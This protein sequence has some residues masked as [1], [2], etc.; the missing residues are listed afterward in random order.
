[1]TSQV[2]ERL[3]G[4]SILTLQQRLGIP[5]SATHGV[6]R[7]A[8]WAI[9][10]GWLPLAVIT[11]VQS[12]IQP[13][14][15]LEAFFADRGLQC[16]ALIAAPVLIVGRAS[17]Y[18]RLSRI[19]N[20]FLDAD[21]ISPQDRPAFE[22]AIASTR[23]LEASRWAMVA[24]IAMAYSLVL[25]LVASDPALPAWHMGPRTWL[26]PYSAAGWWHVVVSLPMLIVLLLGWFW[27]LVLWARL[28]WVASCARLDLVPPH[29]DRSAGL[30]F[31]GY[32]VR[33][34][35]PV[36]FALGVIVAGA[37]ANTVARHELPLTTYRNVCVGL[38]AFVI[39]VFSAPLLAFVRPLTATWQHAIHDYGAF[40]HGLGQG[41]E[42][43][44]LRG[45]KPDTPALGLQD[46]SA[47]NDLY[48]CAGTVYTIRVLPIDTQSLLLLAVATVLPIL[49]VA[50]SSLPLDVVGGFIKGLLI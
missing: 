33:A 11:V 50:V 13:W 44:W 42:R 48:Q 35:A 8:A 27:R 16:R 43:K 31:V 47:L 1:V 19:Y 5:G 15:G 46:F 12:R 2:V 7:Q 26:M 32:S 39:V 28:L 14:A 40:A 21:I 6:W 36:G 25:G 45:A 30:R 9:G 3:F 22:A 4:G 18:A 10:I 23:R 49:V 38:L 29:P 20:Y 34:F 41:F 17:A 37:L 24:A